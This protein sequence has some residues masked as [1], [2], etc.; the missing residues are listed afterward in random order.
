[1]PKHGLLDVS[2]LHEPLVHHVSVFNEVLRILQLSGVTYRISD[3][4][5]RHHG[6][7]TFHF[8]ASWYKHLLFYGIMVQAPFILR[9]HDTITFCF[10]ASWYSHLSYYGIMIQEPFIIRHHGTITFYFTTSWYKYILFYGIVVQTLF[11]LL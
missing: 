2:Y 6:T 10:T 5:L 9:H 1:M 8:T 4:I 3:Y 11:Y 7:S